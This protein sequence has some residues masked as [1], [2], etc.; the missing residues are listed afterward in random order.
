VDEDDDIDRLLHELG[1]ELPDV[2]DHAPNDGEPAS[3][4]D[5]EWWEEWR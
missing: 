5:L 1:L 3:F 4:D 2:A